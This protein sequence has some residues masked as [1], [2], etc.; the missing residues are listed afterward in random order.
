MR[1]H[2]FP[3]EVSLPLVVELLAALYAAVYDHSNA[4]PLI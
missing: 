4:M 3:I 2:R 1:I